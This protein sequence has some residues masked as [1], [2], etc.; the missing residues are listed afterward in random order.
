[1]MLE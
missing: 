1:M